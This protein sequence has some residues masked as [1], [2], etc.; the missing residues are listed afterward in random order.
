M[1][2]FAIGQERMGCALEFIKGGN[3]RQ[4]LV[5]DL[6]RAC[7]QGVIHLSIRFHPIVHPFRR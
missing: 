2:I 5:A 1:R 4:N 6:K 3:E 7:V